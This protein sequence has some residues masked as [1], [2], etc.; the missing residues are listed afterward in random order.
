MK[1]TFEG[2]SIYEVMDAVNN[3][4]N[5][6]YAGVKKNEAE[7]PAEAPA[8]DPPAEEPKP[9]KRTR[10]KAADKKG[11]KAD[12]APEPRRRRSAKVAEAKDP[13]A[14]DPPEDDGGDEIT[15]EDVM[16]AASEAAKDITPKVVMEILEQFGVVN[17][18]DLDQAQRRKFIGQLNEAK[19]SDN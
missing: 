10:A 19:E 16:K 18:G 1:I 17:V 3:F 12:D 7:K 2:K 11:E 6:I 15:D 4:L 14:D 8:E 13:P 9:K 5:D